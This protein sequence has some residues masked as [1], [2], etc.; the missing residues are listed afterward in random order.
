MGSRHPYPTAH[1]TPDTADGPFRPGTPDRVTGADG[2]YL[3]DVGPDTS[4]RADLLP[5]GT[6]TGVPMSEAT[7]SPIIILAGARTPMGRFQGGLA[8]RTATD[9]GAVA[10]S[11]GQGEALVLRV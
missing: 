9:L 4:H 2:L 7:R 5:D 11:G 1:A 10:I 8:S 3:P 6:P